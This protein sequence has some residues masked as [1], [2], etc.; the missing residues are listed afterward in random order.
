[1]ISDFHLPLALASSSKYRKELLSRLGLPFTTASPDIDETPLPAE[2]PAET[3][4]RLACLKAKAVGKKFPDA[5][6]IG[7]DQVAECDGEAIGKP[8]TFEN[9][10]AQLKKMRGKKVIF[11]TALCV[12]NGRDSR[13]DENAQKKTVDTCVTF[14]DLPDD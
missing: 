11:H 4:L 2:T 13:P 8:G 7:S 12:W 14:R 10:F 9:A 3:A 1:M 6:V 5:V